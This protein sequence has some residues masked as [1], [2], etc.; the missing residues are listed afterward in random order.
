MLHISW[1]S[2][3]AQV[4]S[5]ISSSTSVTSYITLQEL[6]LNCEVRIQKTVTDCYKV[7]SEDWK[8]CYVNL[9]L[10]ML[11]QTKKHGHIKFCA[12]FKSLLYCPNMTECV[13]N[14]PK[15]IR[16][17]STFQS[18][19]R[20]RSGLVVCVLVCQLGTETN[21]MRIRDYSP[22]WVIHFWSPKWSNNAIATTFITLGVSH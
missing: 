1:F 14:D 10:L 15:N 17:Q 2:F 13:Y 4:T 19:D 11:F 6:T 7:S 8:K 9:Y 22:R 16:G 5:S 21:Y 18:E 3:S 12:I 20:T